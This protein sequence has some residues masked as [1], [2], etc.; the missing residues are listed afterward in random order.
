MVQRSPSKQLG[1]YNYIRNETRGS[2]PPPVT[3]HMYINGNWKDHRSHTCPRLLLVEF[4][5]V[6]WGRV[7]LL[8]AFPWKTSWDG[9]FVRTHNGNR[10]DH[11]G[12]RKR[13]RRH[14]KIQLGVDVI[15][16]KWG[17]RFQTPTSGFPSY[18]L[19][20]ND[21]CWGEDTKCDPCV[22]IV[23][24]QRLSL[25]KRDICPGMGERRTFIP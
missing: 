25:D 23:K 15:W 12:G 7:C 4:A 16:R 21:N 8:W 14:S 13:C 18:C 11:Q 17:F 6:R 5:H 2:F 1:Y 22:Y 20:D 3:C 24:Q 10:L 19:W 9:F